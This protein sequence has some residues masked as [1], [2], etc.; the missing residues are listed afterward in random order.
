MFHFVCVFQYT[1]PP[2]R[3]L[4]APL[5]AACTPHH[6]L[7]SNCCVNKFLKRS[8]GVRA[9]LGVVLVT[10]FIKDFCAGNSEKLGEK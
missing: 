4:R 3:R 1:A 10:Y 9:L 8:C 2:A 6:I 5:A 7:F